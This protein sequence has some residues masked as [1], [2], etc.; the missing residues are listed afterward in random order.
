MRRRVPTLLCALLLCSVLVGAVPVAGAQQTDGTHLEAQLQPDGD[1]EWTVS[2]RLPISSDDEREAFE[3]LAS[4]FEA[5]ESDLELGEDAFERAVSEASTASGREM[6]LESPRR[7]SE[8]VTLAQNGDT[9]EAYGELRLEFSWESFARVGENNTLYIDD[10]FNTTDGTWLPGLGADQTLTIRAPAEYG[11]PTTSPIGADEGDLYWEGPKTFEPGYFNIVYQPATTDPVDTEGIPTLLIAG[12]LVLSGAALL[13]GVYLL[14]ARRRGEDTTADDSLWPWSDDDSASTPA[15]EPPSA[16]PDT[17]ST[18][19]DPDTSEPEAEPDLDLFSDAERVEYLLERNGGRMK[20]ATIV[21]ET[22][23]SNA[24]VSQ[25]LSSMD[26]DDQVDKLRIG[27]E[28]LISLPGEGVGE[29][30]ESETPD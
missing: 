1:A 19:A 20:Q 28:N 6:A 22:G 4:R 8:V 12:A 16:E 29:L 3:A 26:D 14:M 15:S 23:W 10:A 27:R 24:K 9:P 13:L 17:P 18:P 11:A 2:V 30:D 21:K 25:L 7:D 5:G